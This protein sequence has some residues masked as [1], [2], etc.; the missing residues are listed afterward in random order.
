MS[1]VNAEIFTKKSNIRA[2]T[3]TVLFPRRQPAPR[4][5]ISSIN[6]ASAVIGMKQ[7]AIILRDII[8]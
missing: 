6:V 4:V 8:I 1:V 5:N 7:K 2:D 3:V